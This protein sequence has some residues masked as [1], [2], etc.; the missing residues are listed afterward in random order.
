MLEIE[1]DFTKTGK[2][3]NYR[4]LAW[5]ALTWWSMYMIHSHKTLQSIFSDTPLYDNWKT[6]SLYLFMLVVGIN[7][8]LIEIFGVIKNAKQKDKKN[9]T[10]KII[11]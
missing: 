5:V 2:Y 11:R 1:I 8:L 4:V 7:C 3:R 9:R 6:H 10:Q